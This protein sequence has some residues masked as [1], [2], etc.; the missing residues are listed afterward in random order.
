M[1][2]RHLVLGSIVALAVATPGAQV[3]PVTVTAIR[4]VRIITMDRGVIENGTLVMTDGKI[5]AVGPDVP[6]PAGAVVIDGAG[7]TAMPGIIDTEGPS[8]GTV[9]GVT[10]PMRAQL[11]A[12]DYFD[13]YGNDY[14]VERQ[15]RDFVEWGVTAINVKLSD[16]VVF[17]SVSS[18]VK[19]H[20]PTTYEDHFV[21]YRAALRINLGEPPKSE[22]NQF[23]TT[24]MGIAGEVRQE[25]LKAQDYMK[26]RD[27]APAADADPP[28]RDFKLDSLVSAL[29]GELP[30]MIHA[31]EPMD[32]ETAIRL[33]D[34][35]KFRLVLS[36]SAEALESQV[37]ELVSRNIPV[38]LGTYY[39]FINS[40]TGE[41]TDF[42]YQTAGM[43]ARRGITVA[44]GGLAGE[45]KLLSA[46]AGIAVQN[47]MAYD[48]ALKALTTNPARILRI[49]D[50]VGSLT[51]GKDA[52]VVLYRG[53]PL[54]IT[55][56]V[57]KVW[58]GG[59][60][61][62]DRATFDPTYHNLKVK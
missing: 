58:I 6:A 28:A 22:Q 35:F 11:I 55:S 17:D 56:P 49:D 15:L 40:H 26:R 20:A 27:A 19:V 62:Y 25:F 14:R 10:G 4:Q 39:S 13:P 34:E 46:N 8:R 41:L 24:R 16:D 29:K 18:V 51:P 12:G 21:K 52:D 3:A 59:R 43:L 61:V 42:N 23:P 33:A 44:F 9:S 60:L 57:V 38:V 36:A 5:S 37:P 1:T 32:V 30:V 50:R 7:L 31:V 48:D 53:D 54:E 47:G 45:T 2:R